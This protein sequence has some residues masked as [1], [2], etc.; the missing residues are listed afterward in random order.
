MAI[1]AN[2]VGVYYCGSFP[3]EHQHDSGRAGQS[4]AGTSS[5]GKPQATL[6]LP[7]AGRVPE[8][9]PSTNSSTTSSLLNSVQKTFKKETLKRALFKDISAKI[10]NRSKQPLPKAELEYLEALK[11]LKLGDGAQQELK[12]RMQQLDLSIHQ[13]YHKLDI[14]QLSDLVQNYYVKVADSMERTESQLYTLQPAEKTNVSN[15]L[16]SCVI[17]RNHK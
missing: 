16:E 6:S 5:G 17:S 10:P 12:M 2:Q 3:T 15:F 1:A 11:A 4:G 9:T 7:V 14:D 8:L 13:K